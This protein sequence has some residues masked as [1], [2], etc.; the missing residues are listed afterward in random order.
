[1]AFPATDIDH[2]P[3]ADPGARPRVVLRDVT[4]R[5]V[6]RDGT[7]VSAL[8]DVSLEVRPGEFVVLL[9]PSGCG[10][11]TLLRC[12]A[13][14]ERP[15]AGEIILKGKT[16]FSADRGTYLPPEERDI[17]MMFQTYALWPHMTVR[18]NIAYPLRARKVRPD[19]TNARVD[20]IMST[21]EIGHLANE[22]PAQLSGGQQ[23][24]VGLARSLVTDPDVVVFDEPLSNLDARV[25]KRLRVE[26]A[27]MQRDYGFSAIYVTHDQEEAMHI[28]DRIV[29]MQD[30]G[31]VRVGDS[32]SIYERPQT[33]YVAGFIGS[34]NELKGSVVETY[35]EGTRTYVLADTPIGIVRATLDAASSYQQGEDVWLG[36]RPEGFQLLATSDVSGPRGTQWP[37]HIVRATFLG[38]H[39]EYLVRV[40]DTVVEAW[41]GDTVALPEESEIVLSA[42]AFVVL[43]R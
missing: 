19:E 18:K 14:L 24:R 38:T 4:K 41:S 1:M 39:M 36:V 5:F 27:Q 11:T 17:S 8:H 33:R 7:S 43:A 25:R 28:A 6:R 13:G 42:T 40:G 15:D 34:F 31:L 2:A 16:V 9:G 20:R 12:V 10:K 23:Q 30:G 37:A 32:R 3:V 21:M 22:Y 26:V 35:N 29:M